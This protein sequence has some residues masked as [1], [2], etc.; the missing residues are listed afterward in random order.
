MDTSKRLPFW[1][2]QCF[3]GLLSTGYG[4]TSNDD[5]SYN[6]IA[7]A[8]GKENTDSFW[9]PFAL[10]G[11]YYWPEDKLPRNANIETFI[12]LYEIEGDFV[13]CNNGDLEEGLEKIAL[14][15][16]DDNQIT[17]VARQQTDGI[18]TSKLGDWE[19]ID[20]RTLEG[21][22]GPAPAYG[23]IVQFLQRPISRPPKK[24]PRQ[25]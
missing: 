21:V 20:H 11:G 15:A 22:A 24:T 9:T 19:D 23:T 16:D 6:C 1:K 2:E 14:Y 18:W 12:K 4:V 3:P 10:G 17:H 7:W 13:Q 8:A 5:P 25:A